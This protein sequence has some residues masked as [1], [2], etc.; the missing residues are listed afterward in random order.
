[1]SKSKRKRYIRNIRIRKYIA[2]FFLLASLGVFIL[3]VKDWASN[4]LT[5]NTVLFGLGTLVLFFGMGYAASPLLVGEA[6]RK[7]IASLVTTEEYKNGV[8][9]GKIA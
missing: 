3:G 1:M 7:R 4:G 5:G 6:N 8:R 9:K 2:G